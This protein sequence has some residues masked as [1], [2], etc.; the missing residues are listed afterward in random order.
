MAVD[1]F[2]T[3]KSSKKKLF[4]EFP[5]NGSAHEFSIVQELRNQNDHLRNICARCEAVI[6]V[7]H[8]ENPHVN[9][10]KA[11]SIGDIPSWLSN[12]K[13]ISP[14]LQ[15]YDRRI[16]EL[17]T[18][19][20]RAQEE[21]SRL[22]Q[23]I[24]KIDESHD[25]AEKVLKQELQAVL[26]SI[27]TGRGF[28]VSSEELNEAYERI[29]SLKE[30]MDILNSTELEQRNTIKQLTTELIDLQDGL[31]LSNL[32]LQEEGA[33]RIQA[34]D[35]A[36]DV[37]TITQNHGEALHI[38]EILSGKVS[39]LEDENIVISRELQDL[40]EEY[41]QKQKEFQ[42][43][44]E[45][46]FKQRN[47]FEGEFRHT[48]T[49]SANSDLRI[50]ELKHQNEEFK[51][52]KLK[53]QDQAEFLMNCVR[54]KDVLIKDFCDREH[55]LLKKVDE[56]TKRAG[57]C[58]TELEET[59]QELENLKENEQI[60]I[61]KSCSEVQSAKEEKKRQILTMK[62]SFEHKENLFRDEISTLQRQLSHKAAE[63]GKNMRLLN[64]LEQE[65][66][67][68]SKTKM[69]DYILLKEENSKF[70]TQIQNAE[71]KRK[72]AVEQTHRLIENLKN[73]EQERKRERQSLD[74]H[75]HQI[76]SDKARDR[77][78]LSEAQEKLLEFN[79]IS[80]EL[81]RKY[82][83]LTHQNKEKQ[84]FYEEKLETV[85]IEWHNKYVQAEQ[86][87]SNLKDLYLNSEEKITQLLAAQS[88]VG[89]KWK[90]EHRAL[91]VSS[92]KRAR[93]ILM[94]N[95]NLRNSVIILEQ[96]NE[97]LK[98]QRNESHLRQQTQGQEKVALASALE[99]RSGEL[100]QKERQIL[101]F[102]DLQ[103]QMTK[104]NSE[105]RVNL[106]HCE[107][108]LRHLKKRSKE[109]MK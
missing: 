104:E 42:Q 54:E 65:A 52:E 32:H 96:Q 7:Y 82:N 59:I 39:D 29:S 13:H 4:S 33:R 75:L 27:E 71:F 47:Y 20:S 19:N 74:Q 81:K 103:K 55:D 98:H 106:N 48:E 95:E 41:E 1:G 79:K 30:Q 94:E 11:E 68:T 8:A 93:K 49:K 18:E 85:E 78:L 16:C 99:N 21:T 102:Q 31:E 91:L 37:K 60:R 61:D 3:S 28:S 101:Y 24:I 58:V 89:E 109:S 23:E 80:N 2:E 26:E 70:K 36:K 10:S 88:K 57:Q 107:L 15:A 50:V 92:Q 44:L 38:I 46:L 66:F 73:L 86:E 97:R 77:D 63:L 22:Q 9:I 56:E 51:Q 100:G 25:E 14:L 40:Q 64:A 35:V 53:A 62:A 45:S 34:E 5:P 67:E 72:T 90:S 43:E 108:E 17:K 87:I 69:E 84:A 83:N 76:R 12:G 6:K 105:L